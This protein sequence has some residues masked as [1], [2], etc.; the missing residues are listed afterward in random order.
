MADHLSRIRTGEPPTRVDDELPNACLFKV[1][2]T[3]EL[4]PG[5]VEYLMSGR[6]PPELSKVKT[7]KLIRLVGPYQLIARQLYILGKDG[8]LRI[9]ALPHEVDDILFQSHDGLAQGH[10]ASELTTRKVL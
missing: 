3:L 4:Y 6:P 2:Y 1:Y 7:C 5:L 8:V 10:F 9:C